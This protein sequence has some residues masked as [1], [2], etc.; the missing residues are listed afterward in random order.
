MLIRLLLNILKYSLALGL[1]AYV[2]HSNWLP[3]SENGLAAVWQKHAVEGKPVHLF[4]FM[5]SIVLFFTGV[6]MTL[7]RWHMMMLAQDFAL[8]FWTTIKIGF[9]GFFF[10]TL[11]PGSVGGDLVK[12]AAVC[13]NQARRSAAVTVI[14]LDRAIALWGLIFFSGASGAIFWLTGYLGE[15]VGASAT[16]SII[17]ITLGFCSITGL[18]WFILGYLP[19]YRVQRFEGRLRRWIAGPA[20]EFWLTFWSFRCKPF[21][22]AKSL[23]ISWTGH[24]CLTLSFYC[25]AQVL[26]DGQSIPNLLEHFLIVPLGLVIQAAPMFPG[27]AGIGEFGYGAL[28]FWFGADR[29]MGVLA[30]LVQRLA[31]WII[32]F[33]SYLVCIAIPAPD[34]ST[35]TLQ[36]LPPC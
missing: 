23:L 21:V 22:V 6:C 26:C 9:I 25:A 2:I 4:Y 18:G 34:N 35:Q 16:K 12:A 36:D 27:G 8:G 30:S 15:G 11:L 14:V 24:I 1:L 33:S 31:T 5:G 13:K 28:Y 29:A 32:G 19:Q 17:K 10:N 7:I 3:D 20:A